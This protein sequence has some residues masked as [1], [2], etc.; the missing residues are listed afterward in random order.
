MTNDEKR[1]YLDM[2]CDWMKNCWDGCPLNNKRHRCGRGTHFF[3]DSDARMTDYEIDQ[4]YTAVR[5]Y[6][7]K[8]RDE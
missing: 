4:A 8:H 6:R 2:F 1:D 7:E 5:K 3:D